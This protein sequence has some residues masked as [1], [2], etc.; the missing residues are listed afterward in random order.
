MQ[1]NIS[2]EMATTVYNA[3]ITHKRVL[4]DE[5]VEEPREA[6]KHIIKCQLVRI[7]EAIVLFDELSS[8]VF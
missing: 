3:L 7:E 6:V 4:N 1:I 5:L 8:R 2:G